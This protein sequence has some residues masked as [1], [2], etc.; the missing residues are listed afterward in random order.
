MDS[1]CPAPGLGRGRE[2][3]S[4]QSWRC[5]LGTVDE[6]TISFSCP[7]MEEG[8][9]LLERSFETLA[10]GGRVER[11]RGRE[12]WAVGSGK[13]S[14]QMLGEPIRW[15]DLPATLEVVAPVGQSALELTLR[16]PFWEELAAGLDEDELWT[17]VE[18]LAQEGRARCGTV[19]DGRAVGFPGSG[20]DAAAELQR[21]HL[22]VIIPSAWGS[23]LRRGSNP[24]RHLARI[25]LLLFLD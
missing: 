11:D 6:T 23:G 25:D 19:A 7:P 9:W 14:P 22:G 1:T 4:D 2:R 20:P 21:S 13:G 8:P 3:V 17:G 10:R 18:R 16:L 5:C 15:R 12:R 24:Y